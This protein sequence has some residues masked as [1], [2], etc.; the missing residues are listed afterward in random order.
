MKKIYL[1]FA[2]VL[3]QTFWSCKTDENSSEK[4]YKISVGTDEDDILDSSTIYD[5]TKI[6][7]SV[8]VIE[9]EGAEIKQL[10]NEN[11][12]TIGKLNYADKLDIIEFKS[13]WLG[14][15]EIVTCEFENNG[16]KI[17]RTFWDKVYVKR[18]STG[19]ISDIKL[20]NQNL[21]LVKGKNINEKAENSI[22]NKPITDYISIELVEKDEFNNKKSSS[23]KSFI[24]DTADIK[25]NN[26]IIELICGNK[27][28]KFEDKLTEDDEEQEFSYIGQFQIL[29]Q[30]LISCTYYEDYEYKLI[31]KFNGSELNIIDFPF[32]SQDNKHILC[33]K[34]DPY[35]ISTDIELYNIKNNQ[36]K[37]EMRTYFE[38]WMPVTD[39]EEMFWSADGYFYIPVLH[40]AILS[41]DRNN[42]K[43][44]LQYLKIKIL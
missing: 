4:N 23:N 14:V 40:I 31:D 36:I 8:F 26:G 33:V 1:I 27:I 20:N 42:K 5:D 17:K 32:L 11:S 18:S 29:N 41:Y 21:L 24:V 16:E 15:K 2:I 12:K 39:K 25:K 3:V 37:L 38:N 28:V 30:Y 35:S 6:L 43:N 9:N 7:E 13:N 10:D 34:I 44:K 19:K 22:N